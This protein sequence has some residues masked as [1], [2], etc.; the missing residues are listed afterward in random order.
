MDPVTEF[1]NKI[2]AFFGAPYAVAT[3][4]CTS[5]LELCL[6]YTKAQYLTSPTRTYLSVPMLADKLKISL[7]WRVQ[8]WQD[9]YYITRN[10]IDA[11]VLWKPQSYIP[12][13]FMCVSFQY[14]KHLSVGRLGV[15]L[16]SNKGAAENLKMLA[17]D[18]RIPGIPW[19]D[20]NISM[21][22]FHYY[23][24]PELCQIALD[25]L[26]AAI[27]TPPRQWVYTDW[28]DLTEMDIFKNDK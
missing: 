8:E 15:I 12:N 20:Q 25:K 23:P 7:I 28:R 24:Q 18:G 4:S 10:I 22:G 27:A 9:Y 1:E 17:H 13:T 5:A 11:A 6:R 26:D 14:A 21:R 2:A 3:D 19:R 16:C